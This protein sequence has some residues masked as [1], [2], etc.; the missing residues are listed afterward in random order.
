[1]QFDFMSVIVDGSLRNPIVAIAVALWTTILGVASA[2]AWQ[3]WRR[4]RLETDAESRG[5]GVAAMV[6]VALLYIAT[7]LAQ[8]V[9]VRIIYRVG[10]GTHVSV[11]FLGGPPVWPAWAA[12][13]LIAYAHC[14]CAELTPMRSL[15]QRPVLQ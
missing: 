10:D 6:G 15:Q 4:S 9:I 1:M 8:E 12:G 13:V 2:C 3:A 14:L 7:P 5:R 11:C